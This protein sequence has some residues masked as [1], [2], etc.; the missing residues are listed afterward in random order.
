LKIIFLNIT[1]KNIQ[2]LFNINNNE[3]S[4]YSDIPAWGMPMSWSD[5]D[6]NELMEGIKRSI[7]IENKIAYDN[8]PIE[9]GYSWDGPVQR[10]KLLIEEKRYLRTLYSIMENG[11]EEKYGFIKVE[12]LVDNNHNWRWSCISDFHR[13]AAMVALGYERIPAEVTKIIYR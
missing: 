3:L 10:E 4:G 6:V 8:I 1:P 2:E 13:L 7:E 12:I 5:Y 9:Y 11:F